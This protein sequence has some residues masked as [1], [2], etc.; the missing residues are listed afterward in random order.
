MYFEIIWIF[1]QKSQQWFYDVFERTVIQDYSL[2]TDAFFLIY[3]TNV[4]TGQL[5]LFLLCFSA[6]S[7]NVIKS[8]CLFMALLRHQSNTKCL[9]RLKTAK[10]KTLLALYPVMLQGL[11]RPMCSL[12][13]LKPGNSPWID[14]QGVSKGHWSYTRDILQIGKKKFS[15]EFEISVVQD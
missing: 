15:A 6:Y 1:S 10:K 4:D 7:K 9:T 14:H 2:T 11:L 13:R 8:S 5:D 12:H 3:F